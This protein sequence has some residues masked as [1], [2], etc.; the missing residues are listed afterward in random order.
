M[1]FNWFYVQSSIQ[2]VIRIIVQGRKNNFWI[3][4]VSII[5]AGTVGMEN[6]Y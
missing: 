5:G 6:K 4:V 3:E 1:R 2:L